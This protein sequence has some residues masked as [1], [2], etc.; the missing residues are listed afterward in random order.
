MRIAIQTALYKSSEDLPRLIAS[1]KEQ[2][3][4]DWKFFAYENSCDQAEY[5]RVEAILKESGIP[6]ELYTGPENTGFAGGHNFLFSK[7]Q[8]EFALLLN[9]DAYL[10]E[11]YLEA[12][13][14]RF[15]TD[16]ACAAITGPVYR[17]TT[18]GM[19]KQVLKDE[20]R[21]DTL[22]LKY[23]SLA[24]ISDLGSGDTKFQWHE[25][26]KESHRLFGVSAAVATYRRVAVLEVSIDG[27]LFDPSFFMYKEDVDL[28]IRL[29]RSGYSS[30][31]EPKAISFHRRG[32]QGQKS[33][34]ARLLDERKRPARLRIAMYRNQ[35]AVYAYHLSEN[36]GISDVL[37][38]AQ[39]EML[40]AV[41][42]FLVSPWTF[43]SI[44][45]QI[46]RR[47]PTWLDRRRDMQLAGLPLVRL[48]GHGM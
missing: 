24:E 32:I 43:W 15:D 34:F 30:W 41:G 4:I 29:A 10:E 20:T 23:R 44:W 12:I 3:V 42:T 19:E 1:L 39:T 36:L 26:V 47:L 48:D 7:H 9:D 38:V 5:A 25:W 2:S 28:A 16:A 40:R 18:Q 8:A 6:Y 22:G 14:A 31:F 27:T 13:L 46:L 33:L 11:G 45:I 21:I 17:W 35:W 37:R